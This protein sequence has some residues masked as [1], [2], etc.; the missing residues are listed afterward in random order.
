MPPERKE[1]PPERPTLGVPQLERRDEMS[2]LVAILAALLPLAAGVGCSTADY[3]PAHPVPREGPGF[4]ERVLCWGST[5][6]AEGEVLG[7]ISEGSRGTNVYFRMPSGEFRVLRVP[8]EWRKDPV[9]IRN[10]GADGTLVERED[11][12]VGRICELSPH[13]VYWPP[14]ESKKKF[15]FGPIFSLDFKTTTRCV[16]RTWPNCTEPV[17]HTLLGSSGPEYLAVV[18]FRSEQNHLLYVLFAYDPARLRWVRLSEPMDLGSPSTS[19]GWSLALLPVCLVGDAARFADD[20]LTTVSFGQGAPW[21]AFLQQKMP[22]PTAPTDEL[23]PT[24]ARD[25]LRR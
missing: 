11:L 1:R 16:L 5:E 13:D 3:D 12:L 23:G 17:D 9:Q 22:F 10:L 20:V 15:S 25:F 8:Q 18:R 6:V 7:T 2:R 4:T 24:E 19:L 21:S 14:K